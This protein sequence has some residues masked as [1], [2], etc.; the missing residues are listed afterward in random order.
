MEFEVREKN[1]YTVISLMEPL[2]ALTDITPLEQIV[3]D[4]LKADSPRNIAIRFA[5][6]SFINSF[7][8]SVLVRCWEMITDARL[9]LA[10]L[11]A[12]ESVKEFVQIIDLDELI[13][14][15]ETEDELE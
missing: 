6:N 15:V 13:E 7:T 11:N 2:S 12:N 4:L 8:G 10:V 5:D 1:T 3:K 14:F 9:N